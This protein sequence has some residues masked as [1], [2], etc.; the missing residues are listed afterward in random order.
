MFYS[1]TSQEAIKMFQEVIGAALINVSSLIIKMR[2]ATSTV[3]HFHQLYASF[4]DLWPLIGGRREASGPAVWM[5]CVWRGGGFPSVRQAAVRRVKSAEQ[6]RSGSA[7]HHQPTPPSSVSARSVSFTARINVSSAAELGARLRSVIF[8]AMS[9]LDVM[10]QV[11]GPQPYFSSYGPYHH[12]VGRSPGWFPPPATADFTGSPETL[13]ISVN[14]PPFRT[15]D[16]SCVKSTGG[17]LRQL[18]FSA[19][20]VA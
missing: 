6:Q 5:V 13:A 10:Y 19:V 3:H 20:C 17:A 18:D 11:F 9:C 15:S 16:T 2:Q 1:A 14:A 4:Q 8:S 7:P 12:Q